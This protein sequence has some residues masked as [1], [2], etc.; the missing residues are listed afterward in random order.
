MELHEY[1]DQTET[2]EE[3]TGFVVDTEEKANW[4]L[5]KI[6]QFKEKA[7]GNKKLAQ[8]EIGRIEE[9]LGKENNS[10]SDSIEH[11]EFLL[12]GY[13]EKQKAADPKF[14]SMKLPYGKLRFKKQQPEFK[15][16]EE[17]LVLFLKNNGLKEK[18]VETKEKPKWGEFKK[19]AA[20]EKRV[21]KRTVT[22]NEDKTNKEL[23]VLTNLDPSSFES[24]DKVLY[25]MSTG[26][27]FTNLVI[28]DVLVYNG[29]IVDGVTVIEREDKFEVEV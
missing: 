12:Q 2:T 3:N 25:D 13:A 17:P 28:K 7:D 14:K 16:E 27:V 11:F 1:L 23:E 21:Y 5:R 4:T 24:K 15:Q 10:L 22:I 8:A 18:Y 29:S 19:V 9:W 6:R 20:I 26:E